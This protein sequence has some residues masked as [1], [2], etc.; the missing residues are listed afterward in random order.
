MTSISSAATADA[1]IKMGMRAECAP[2]DIRPAFPGYSI[3]GPAAPITYLG[4]YDVVL[5]AIGEA[6]PGS[7]LVIDNGGRSDE[8]CVTVLTALEAH[9]SGIA[10]IVIW[11]FHRDT[12]QLFD[13]G[14]PIFSLGA[15]PRGPLRVPPSSIPMRSALVGGVIVLPG[16]QVVA[17]D[18]GIVFVP[19]ESWD[20]AY[21]YAS[22]ITSLEAQRTEQ[23]RGGASLR[24]IID[25]DGYLAARA[26]H[27][28]YSLREHVRLRD[29]SIEP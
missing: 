7:I 19:A 22:R 21:G 5:E 14:I 25:F 15:F 8:A 2:A 29:N 13:I 23:M 20:A 6:E 10:G 12:S 1:L 18:D 26:K 11:G 16:D 28:G 3:S 4:S 9:E 17:D 27:P 24:D